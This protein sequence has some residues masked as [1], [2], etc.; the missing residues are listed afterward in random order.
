MRIAATSCHRNF[1]ATTLRHAY[2][3]VEITFL[4]KFPASKQLITIRGFESRLRIDFDDSSRDSMFLSTTRVRTPSIV[5]QTRIV[6][7]NITSETGSLKP[8]HEVAY[9]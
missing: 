8:G 1:V 9:H 7:V 4:N 5:L 3:A 6:D 2:R